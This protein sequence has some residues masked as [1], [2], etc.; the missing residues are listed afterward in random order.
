VAPGGGTGTWFWVSAIAAFVFAV[1]RFVIAS[2]RSGRKVNPLLIL[3][4][5]AVFGAGA[6]LW[7]S[8][9][10]WQGRIGLLV[11]VAFAWAWFHRDRTKLELGPSASAVDIYADVLTPSLFFPQNSG[12]VRLFVDEGTIATR[13]VNQGTTSLGW[14]GFDRLTFTF[15]AADCEVERPLTGVSSF[16]VTHG[17][18][19]VVLRG[20]GRR[21]EVELAL[22]R[23]SGATLEDV[24]LALIRAGARPAHAQLEEPTRPGPVIEPERPE[25]TGQ[26][27]ID[28]NASWSS[29]GLGDQPPYWPPPPAW[30]TAHGAATRPE[31]PVAPS[32]AD[33]WG[34]TKRGVLAL[35]GGM[36][37][38]AWGVVV[39]GLAT[40]GNEEIRVSII[41]LSLCLAVALTWWA[42]ELVVREWRGRV[43]VVTAAPVSG[44]A[45]LSVLWL[46]VLV[47]QWVW[48]VVLMILFGLPLGFGLL[49]T[50]LARRRW[51][52]NGRQMA[53]IGAGVAV[54][55]ALLFGLTGGGDFAGG[56]GLA[57]IAYVSWLG[58]VRSGI[59]VERRRRRRAPSSSGAEAL[60]T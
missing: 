55:F 49:T 4:A 24:Q 46:A 52:G 2:R 34:V 31:E 30:I 14:L 20:P 16:L 60:P 33:R 21:G 40:A 39:L 35:C 13:S 25:P 26:L 56:A 3:F 10:P 42:T 17:K 22:A 9:S 57:G 47:G 27:P 37:A 43:G 38:A 8:H 58:G 50:V 18:P 44:L 59:S 29:T 6:A 28:P 15:R 53:L 54:T 7:G 19:A 41:V 45:I 1:S 36:M 23:P 11:P 51:P 32:L 5:L 12:R 48:P